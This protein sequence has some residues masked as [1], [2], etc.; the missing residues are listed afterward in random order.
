MGK[1][2]NHKKMMQEKRD[3]QIAEAEKRKEEAEKRIESAKNR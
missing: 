3:S 1:P 2:E